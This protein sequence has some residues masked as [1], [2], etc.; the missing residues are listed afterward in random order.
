MA[1]E[2]HAW[3]FKLAFSQSPETRKTDLENYNLVAIGD[4]H[5]PAVIFI[6]LVKYS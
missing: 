6:R 1:K 3:N 5:L 2:A 4:L